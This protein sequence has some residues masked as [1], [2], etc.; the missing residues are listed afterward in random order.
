MD[1][2]TAY[3]VGRDHGLKMGRDRLEKLSDSHFPKPSIPIGHRVVWGHVENAAVQAVYQASRRYDGA[4]R[5]VSD[6]E[7]RRA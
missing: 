5:G 7:K 4:F 1:P 2:C 3:S 6:E